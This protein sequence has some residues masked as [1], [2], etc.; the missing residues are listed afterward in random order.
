MFDTREKPRM[1]ESAFL[2]GAYFDRA[3]EASAQSL[4][5]ELAELVGT[6]GIS[7]AGRACVFVRDRNKRYLTGSGKAHELI[8]EAEKIGADCI[9][10]DNELAPAQQRAWE[11][12]GDITVIDREEV[13]LDIFRMRA[14]TREARL[15]VELA[16]MQ[17]SLPRLARM[18][19]H[20]DR[21]RGGSGGGKGGGAASRGEG[22]Q[23][24]EVDRR[25]AR[26]RIERIKEELD[27][28]RRH[29]QTQRKQRTDEGICQASIV[30]YTNA[31]KSSLLNL[32][33][34]AE[35]LA[36]DKLFATLDPTTRRIELPDGQTLLLTDTVGFVRNLPHRLVEA[37]KATLEE[38]VLADFL[39]HVL[40]ASA[41]EI[42]AFHETTLSVLRELGAADKPTLT[43]LNKV[44][45]IAGD[46][47]RLH[48]LK[49]HFEREA[50]FVSV[51]SGEGIPELVNRM[52][53]LM[54]DRVSR[55]QLRVPQSRQDLIA[56]LHREG[57]IVGQDY[58]G[59][60]ILLTAIVPHPLRH[61]FEPFLS[62]S[63]GSESGR[64]LS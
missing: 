4:L 61:H 14:Q 29:R 23:Q 18:W 44:D 40:D 11:E 32:L 1:V 28:V 31:G 9:V 25:L 17:Y 38:A 12:E 36:E 63:T 16:R 64:S 62:A 41:P 39:I 24:I 6:L 10:F 27:E 19:S 46:E 47:A 56:L 30:G 20:L 33:A 21:Q 48:E 43:V 58:E 52:S 49:R 34:G 15:Q 45:L 57:K 13:I 35:V 42:Y 7:I 22:E 26:S 53:D 50:V 60:D 55:L 59:N 3:D 2:I 54:I 8:E 37:F 5:D 51:H